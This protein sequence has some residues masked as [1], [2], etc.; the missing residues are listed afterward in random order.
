MNK[1]AHLIINEI[2]DLT[3]LYIRARFIKGAGARLISTG[4]LI[5]MVSAG[6]NFAGK[7]HVN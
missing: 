5:L 3:R 7:L 2:G 4:L 1:I 6:I